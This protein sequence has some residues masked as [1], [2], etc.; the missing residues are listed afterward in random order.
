[1]VNHTGR[2]R[3][4]IAVMDPEILCRERGNTARKT[5]KLLRLVPGRGTA[6]ARWLHQPCEARF[7]GRPGPGWRCFELRVHIW[8]SSM[9]I[10]ERARRQR[11]GFRV[12]G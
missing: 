6:R 9:A 7:S 11:C 10:A 1:M 2:A 8:T 3:E 5:E 12:S 4:V